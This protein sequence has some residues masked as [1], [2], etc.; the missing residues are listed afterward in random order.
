MAAQFGVSRPIVGE[1]LARLGDDGFVRSQ[2]GSG[3]FVHHVLRPEII[4]LAPIDSIGDINRCF[5]FR[6]HNEV[7]S[8]ALAAERRTD[9]D[10][11]A[12]R[13]A[14]DSMDRADIA[15]PENVDADFQFH[16]AIA[17]ATQ[18]RYFEMM[19]ELIKEAAAFGMKLTQNTIRPDPQQVREVQAEHEAIFAAILD[20][21]GDA[22]TSEILQHIKRSQARLTSAT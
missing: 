3:T 13:K 2:R 19:M 14:L 16:L 22:A 9:A 1:A 10:L 7:Q 5:E 20:Q 21:Q 15:A 18:N 6:I 17:R 11:A 4:R 12:M 8:V